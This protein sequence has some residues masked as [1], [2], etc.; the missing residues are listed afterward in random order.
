MN[1]RLVVFSIL[2]VISS[3]C[4]G[5]YSSQVEAFYRVGERHIGRLSILQ[6]I[7]HGKKQLIF[8]NMILM[9]DSGSSKE[10]NLGVGYRL[11]KG[12]QI[13]GSYLYYDIR[14]TSNKNTVHQF[15]IGCEYLRE[16]FELR[17]NGYLPITNKFTLSSKKK[18][19]EL[20]HDSSNVFIETSTI[21]VIERA[22]SG[23][24]FEMGVTSKESLLNMYLGG[25]YFTAK[26]RKIIGPQFRLESRPL[27]WLTLNTEFKYDKIRKTNFYVGFGIRFAIGSKTKSPYDLESKMTQMP[28]RDIDAITST[29]TEIENLERQDLT[30]VRDSNGFK[31]A[32]DRGDKFIGVAEDIDFGN[33]VVDVYGTK[34]NPIK[35][36][37]ITGVDLTISNGSITKISQQRKSFKNF[38]LPATSTADSVEI[39]RLRIIPGIS[40]YAID[41]QSVLISEAIFKYIDNSYIGYL[42]SDSWRK[43][44]DT[45]GRTTGAAGLVGLSSNSTIEYCRNNQNLK[46][47]QFGIAGIIINNSFLYYNENYGT[48][49]SH[50]I[51][52]ISTGITYYAENSTMD[53][54]IN[55]GILKRDASGIVQYANKS[56]ILNNINKLDVKEYSCGILST[57]LDSVL[58]HNENHG[59]VTDHSYAIYFGSRNLVENNNINTGSLDGTSV[60]E[61]NF[62]F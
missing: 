2:L 25:Y 9:Q 60:V 33:T 7:K 49:N 35:D 56:K 16:L 11:L 62:K 27:D 13:L 37:Y 15:T 51:I 28:I 44:P 21:S 18:F 52:G 5:K 10:G 54:N 31:T 1:H 29:A 55:H 58:K 45:S 36:L 20:S 24:D 30:I 38:V 4:F 43:N 17:M 22:F 23:L 59:S 3:T 61:G 39:T 50:P 53:S 48:I 8:A 19:G 26:T 12:K 57:S 6:P 14:R 47:G 46:K 40:S 42:I 32:M 41:T 34:D